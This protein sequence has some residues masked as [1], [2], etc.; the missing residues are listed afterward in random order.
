MAM[1]VSESTRAEKST[2]AADP[3]APADNGIAA[4]I[5]DIISEKEGR[6]IGYEYADDKSASISKSRDRNSRNAETGDCHL[7]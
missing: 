4:Y 2:S 5:I 7:Y 3:V 6:S 1:R